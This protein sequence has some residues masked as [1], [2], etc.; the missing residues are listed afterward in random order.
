VTTKRFLLVAATALEI[1]AIFLFRTP[2]GTSAAAALTVV[3]LTL[4]V[5]AL[6]TGKAPRRP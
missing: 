5:V 6:S 3:G 1:F 4:L 2:D